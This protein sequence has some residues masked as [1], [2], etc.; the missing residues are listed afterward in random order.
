MPIEWNIEKNNL[1]LFQV[2]GQLGKEEYQNIQ[3]EIQFIIHKT[4]HIRI[5]VILKDFTGWEAAKG[6]EDTSAME[7]IDPYIIK[8]AIVGDEKWRDLVEVFTLKGLR[9]VPIQYFE[10]GQEQAARQWLEREG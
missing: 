6:W 4:G 7:K 8:F 2:S 10:T 3:S 5:L 1:A 9:P